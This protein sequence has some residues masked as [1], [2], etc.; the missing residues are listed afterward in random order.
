MEQQRKL[1]TIRNIN[2]ILPHPNAD[3]LA[4]AV[5]D[6]WKVV[7]GKDEFKADQAVVYF[8]IDSLLPIEEEFE[9]LRKYAFV[10]KAWLESLVPNGEGFR[11]RTIRLRGQISQ[12]LVIPIP[13][14]LNKYMYDSG[15][16][17]LDLDTYFN[18]VKYDPPAVIANGPEGKRGNFPD[19][20]H[21]TKQERV[22]N[23][24]RKQLEEA[25]QTQEIFEITRKYDGE[26]ITVYAVVDKAEPTIFSK[27]KDVFKNFFKVEV[28]SQYRTGV[29]SHNIEL[30]KNLKNNRFVQVATTTGLFDAVE[31]ICRN[32][33]LELAI[34]GEV[35]GPGIRG[36]R[37]GFAEPTIVVFD[38]FDIV[39]QEYVLPDRRNTLMAILTDQCGF[40][41][42][43]AKQELFSR[44]LISPDV[45][46][47][48]MLSEFKL[49]TGK[50]N[51][52][53]VYKSTTRDF[54]F[55]AISNAYL[56][57]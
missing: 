54:S 45:D 2:Q 6:G 8:E 28:I 4:I 17:E 11:I 31:K 26:S 10:K 15:E 16:V 40:T 33:N 29:C 7:V 20:I 43:H 22:Q 35:C 39:A 5:I 18:V 56:L 48:L 23:L 36:N 42:L 3:R 50:E 52:G 30:D 53:L 32:M 34:Q 13:D 19:F 1:V 49:A 24:S 57:E 14:H 25:F 51:E 27:I 44:P 41:G 21:K 37:H 55:K 12:G 46:S 47:I 38:I 9:F